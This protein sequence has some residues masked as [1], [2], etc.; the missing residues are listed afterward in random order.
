VDIG[1]FGDDMNAWFWKEFFPD[2]PSVLPGVALFGIGSI[3]W[4]RNIEQFDR[5]LVMG[6]GTG[7][8]VLP[9]QMPES[10]KYSWVRGPMT[11]SLLGLESRTAVTDPASLV[12]RSEEFSRLRPS[13]RGVFI[14]HVGT[15]TL[16]ID[17]DKISASAGLDFLSPSLE[18]RHV[19]ARIAE[20]EHVVTES[21]HGAILANAFGVPWTPMAISPRFSTFKWL[22]WG[23]SVGLDLEIPVALRRSKGV[24]ALAQKW[25]N[26]LRSR[27]GAARGKSAQSTV[28]VPNATVSDPKAE[29]G[30]SS[31]NKKE[32][33]SL[34]SAFSGL[35]ELA[36]ERELKTAVRR[37]PYLSDRA[38]MDDLHDQMLSRIDAIRTGREVPKW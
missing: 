15:A 8:G 37:R 1:N 13:K 25:R 9:K 22:D 10:L 19:I 16:K 35:L 34:A 11:A 12:V 20:S 36:M 14:P 23:K 30:L 32:L 18:S 4:K 31:E 24:Y 33:R 28:I 6:S 29:F 27:G 26:A 7:V 2:F 38:R 17:W 3:L 21:L 5:I